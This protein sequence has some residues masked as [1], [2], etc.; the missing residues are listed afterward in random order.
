MAEH[1]RREGIA[2]ALVLCSSS[3]RTRETLERISA[4]LP[5]EVQV[6]IEVGVY[7]A[8]A[9]DLLQR[10]RSVAGELESVMLIGHLPALQQLALDLA[11]TGAQVER[12]ERKFPTGA[13]ATLAFD[14]GWRELAH[15]SADLVG[16]ATPRELD[17]SAA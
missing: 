9:S 17:R 6:L 4:G 11:R 10:L 16:F 8:S 7:T 1:L 2:P 13:L 12:I 15:G 5:D 14:A 3:R